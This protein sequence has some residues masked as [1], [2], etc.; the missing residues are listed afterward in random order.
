MTLYSRSGEPPACRLLKP[1]GSFGPA[2][3]AGSLSVSLYWKV[4]FTPPCLQD[5]THLTRST[6]PLLPTPPSCCV[7]LSARADRLYLNKYEKS[8]CTPYRIS[9]WFLGACSD[10]GRQ[11]PGTDQTTYVTS[12]ASW[13]KANVRFIGT[14]YHHDGVLVTYFAW[15]VPGSCGL[16]SLRAPKNHLGIR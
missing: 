12:T 13:C 2:L 5:P 7:E 6:S 11:P 9:K 15:F 3:R 1:L 4:W 16:R 14:Y 8:C 10:H